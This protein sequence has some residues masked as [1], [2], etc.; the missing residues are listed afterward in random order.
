MKRLIIVFALAM[1][2]LM[3]CDKN[4]DEEEIVRGEIKDTSSQAEDLKFLSDLFIEISSISASV[5]CTNSED[6][7]LVA[8]GQKACGGPVGFMAYHQK[9]DENAFLS[10]VKFYTHQQD[11]Y[12]IKWGIISDCTIPPEPSDIICE[13]GLPVFLYH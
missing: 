1:G 13:D 7:K 5:S 3:A 2:I 4:N 12:N 9:I 6:W 8:Y 10:K 11:L